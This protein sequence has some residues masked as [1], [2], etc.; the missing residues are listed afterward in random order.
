MAVLAIVDQID[1][2]LL[3]ARDYLGD[4]GAEFL[5]VFLLV[6]GRTSGEARGRVAASGRKVSGRPLVVELDQVLWAR[7]AARMAGQYPA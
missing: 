5:L 3:L 6:G 7:E 2:G 1:P 4:R